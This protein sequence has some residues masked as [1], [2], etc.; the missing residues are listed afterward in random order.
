[1]TASY[2]PSPAEVASHTVRLTDISRSPDKGHPFTG[3]R[4]R[5]LQKK[6]KSAWT[7]AAPDD[8]G[9]VVSALRS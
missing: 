9:T 8:A 7:G 5:R 6:W 1:M 4:Y 2:Y 3:G